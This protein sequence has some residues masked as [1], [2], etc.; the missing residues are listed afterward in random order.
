MEYEIEDE[1]R[2]FDAS[3]N[4]SL[5]RKRPTAKDGPVSPPNAAPD[6]KKAQKAEHIPEEEPEPQM[7]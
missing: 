4:P 7:A 2:L 6:A 5:E 1:T 3:T